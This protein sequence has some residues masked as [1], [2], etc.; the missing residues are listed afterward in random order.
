MSKA[1][2]SMLYIV[3]GLYFQA[4]LLFFHITPLSKTYLLKAMIEI[5]A[6]KVAVA[7]LKDRS[8]FAK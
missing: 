5:R 3:R 6:L 1:Y 2:Y 8:Y 7:K 4:F